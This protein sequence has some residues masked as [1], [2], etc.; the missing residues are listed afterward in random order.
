VDKQAKITACLHLPTSPKIK[1]TIQT[2]FLVRRP[3]P[4]ADRGC[5]TTV[6]SVYSSDLELCNK[7]KCFQFALEQWCGT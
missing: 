2:V 5:L 6:S 7:W 4:T 1:Y 3:T